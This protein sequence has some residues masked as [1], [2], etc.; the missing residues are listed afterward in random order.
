MQEETKRLTSE[1]PDQVNDDNIY[2]IPA[3]PEP[4][5][6]QIPHTQLPSV[7]TTPVQVSAYRQ[8][9]V[10]ALS[11][12]FKTQL[13]EC[14]TFQYCSLS[15]YV[16]VRI[17]EHIWQ[18]L[19]TELDHLAEKTGVPVDRRMG[20]VATAVVNIQLSDEYARSVELI[21]ISAI[22]FQSPT[23]PEPRSTQI[24]CSFPTTTSVQEKV[25]HIK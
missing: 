11:N 18:A 12:A 2:S 6:L 1:H 19:R 9:L 15:L 8:E 13:L 14:D 7:S 21:I 25:A 5:Q 24:N 4:S 23:S 17:P 10:T 16:N 3:S 20:Q 22:N